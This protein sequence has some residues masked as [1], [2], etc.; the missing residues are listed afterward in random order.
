MHCVSVLSKLLF[1]RVVIMLRIEFSLKSYYPIGCKLSQ[2]I[3]SLEN[4]N[5]HQGMNKNKKKKPYGISDVHFSSR[6]VIPS[7]WT[8]VINSTLTWLHPIWNSIHL[9]CIH[10][11][12]LSSK[13]CQST[14]SPPGPVMP[15][16]VHLVMKRHTWHVRIMHTHVKNKIDNR[17]LEQI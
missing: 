2:I 4:L 13:Y 9:H 11:S 7:L 17:Q 12:A 14:H 16:A 5:H 6:F 10:V 15:I 1:C 3:S 8:D